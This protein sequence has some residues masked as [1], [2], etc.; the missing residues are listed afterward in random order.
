MTNSASM[1][2]AKSSGRVDRKRPGATERRPGI[3]PAPLLELRLDPQQEGRGLADL[4]QKESAEAHLIACRLTERS[5][6]RLL[7]WLDVEVDPERM[8]ALLHSLRRRV[9]PHHLALSQ[10]GPGRVLV[11]V[12]E[13]APSICVTTLG[14]GGICVSCP[15][16]PGGEQ[17]SWRVILPQGT[18][19]RAFLRGLP[20]GKSAHPAIARLDLLRSKTSLTRRQDRA[21]RTAYELGYFAYPR[22]GSLGDVA[23]ALG[24]GRSA[25]LEILRRATSKLAGRRYGAELKVRAPP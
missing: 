1:L 16:L 3:R 4:L 11:R 7:R 22:Q 24:T 20:G 14:A 17:D 5:P 8:E 12:S 21:L 10:L 15:L 6:R 9:R 2:S 23:R 25:T 18:W 19:T 13:P